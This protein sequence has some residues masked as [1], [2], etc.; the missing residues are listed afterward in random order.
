VRIVHGTDD[1]GALGMA[2]KRGDADGGLEAMWSSFEQAV[3]S[4]TLDGSDPDRGLA[5]MDAVLKRHLGRRFEDDGL[6]QALDPASL[7][8]IGR[9]FALVRAVQATQGVATRE[10]RDDV[11]YALAAVI[12]NL[13]VVAGSL[14][15]DS[16]AGRT[17]V[18]TAVG[19]ARNAASRAM[20]GLRTWSR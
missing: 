3:L 13:E 19:Y 20:A 15:D 12:A 8:R 7:A 1:A 2:H 18:L 11:G 17:Q 5:E 9:G 10:A 6:A 4:V 16:R 14:G